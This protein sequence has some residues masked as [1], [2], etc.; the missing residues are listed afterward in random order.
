[1]EDYNR[2]V[3]DLLKEAITNENY[4]VNSEKSLDVLREI[5]MAI[6]A[7]NIKGLPTDELCELKSDVEQLRKLLW[8]RLYYLLY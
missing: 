6:T 2:M 3:I 7:A 1:M 5:R 8:R 4:R